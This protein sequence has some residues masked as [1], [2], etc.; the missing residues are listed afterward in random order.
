MRNLLLKI[1]YNGKNYHGYQ[2]QKNAITVQKVLQQRIEK[3]LK[4]K[5]ELKGCSRTD[6]GVHAN[7]Y[8]ASFKTENKIPCNKL[9][10]GLNA[11]LP[12]DIAAKDC[13]EKPLNFHARYSV[14][15]KEYV[16]KLLNSKCPDPI[17]NGLVYWH[18]W[19]LVVTNLNNLAQSFVGTHNF[20]GFCAEPNKRT[21]FTRTIFYFD[22]FNFYVYAKKHI[23]FRH[24]GISSF[25]FT[26]EKADS[27][28]RFYGGLSCANIRISYIH[29]MA[30][31][32]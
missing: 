4:H 25:I 14:K 30:S 9:V 26:M 28:D 8:F 23:L 12:A 20:K 7:E 18:K 5:V 17:N 29:F 2:V 11:I 3:L 19:P 32:S 6:T 13:E 16:Y 10:L 27:M 21:D 1:S 24:L 15:S 31:L 22:V